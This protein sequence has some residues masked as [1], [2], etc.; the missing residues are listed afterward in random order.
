MNTGLRSTDEREELAEYAHNAWAGWMVYMFARGKARRNGSMI[1]P[2]WAVER[3]SRQAVTGYPDL[4]S[5][6]KESDRE[7]ADKIMDIVDRHRGV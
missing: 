1:I 7:E 3:W 4:P 2:K 5:E 6:E